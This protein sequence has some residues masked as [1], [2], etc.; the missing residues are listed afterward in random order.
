M[1][2]KPGYTIVGNLVVRSASVLA[3]CQLNLLSCH[4]RYSYLLLREE[5]HFRALS[6]KWMD[7][8][9]TKLL[10]L[11]HHLTR[12]VSEWVDCVMDL[13]LAI[14]SCLIIGLSSFSSAGGKWQPAHLQVICHL[15]SCWM[16][17]SYYL[18]ASYMPTHVQNYWWNLK[19]CI[20]P[21]WSVDLIQDV[22][23]DESLKCTE[24]LKCCRDKGLAAW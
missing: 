17:H 11:R 8:V 4:W 6:E 20:S 9:K 21:I 18:L 22:N 15:S 7:L 16:M 19:I 1:R 2:S 5:S 13:Q 24:P 12:W 23:L 3:W 14:A 10:K